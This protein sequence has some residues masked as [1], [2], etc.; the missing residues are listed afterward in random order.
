MKKTLLVNALL[1]LFLG[2]FA[3]VNNPYKDKTISLV[4]SKIVQEFNRFEFL[5]SVASGKDGSIYTTNLMQGLVYRIKD[6]NVKTL[7]DFDGMLAGLTFLDDNNLLVTG[8]SD[9]KEAVILQLNLKRGESKIVATV[10]EGIL[11]N[12]IAKLNKNNFLIADSFKGV[13][14]KLNIKDA[15]TSIWLQNDLL[16]SP[17]IEK[18]SPGVNGIKVKGNSVY[19]SNTGKMLM[20]K[21]PLLKGDKAGDP[22][23]LHENVF[24]DDFEMDAQNNIYAATH[25]YD[26]IIKITPQGKVSIIAEA[27]QGVTGCTCLTWKY[28]S[29][30]TLLVSGNGGMLKANKD[31]VV[32]AKIVELNLKEDKN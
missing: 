12:G 20:V 13:I 22:E 16:A 1:F 9:K 6:G 5:E 3:Q 18:Q 7:V 11:L 17:S 23:I 10:P 30:S 14:W 25:I 19:I 24:I 26:K 21:I 2:T 15:S 32:T 27:E 28:G 4:K 31:E 8:T 29:K